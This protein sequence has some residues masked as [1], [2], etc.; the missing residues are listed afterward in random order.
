MIWPGP[1][2]FSVAGEERRARDERHA[3]EMRGVLYREAHTA[4][5]ANVRIM[6]ADKYLN[7]LEGLPKAKADD[8][9]DNRNIIIIHGGLPD[10]DPN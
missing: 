6:A 9:E 4:E 7:R 1:T 3:E 8:A 2:Q 5:Y 10:A